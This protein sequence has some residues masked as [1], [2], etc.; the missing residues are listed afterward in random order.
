M[1]SAVKIGLDSGCISS[2]FECFLKTFSDTVITQAIAFSIMDRSNVSSLYRE[3][4][5]QIISKY[6]NQDKFSYWK[7]EMITSM[8]LILD[9][10][11]I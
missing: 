10:E 4:L 1:T 7:P 8:G 3:R 5:Y 11:S 2:A 6:G 9:D